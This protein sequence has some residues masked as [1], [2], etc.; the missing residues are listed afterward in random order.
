MTNLFQNEI[1]LLRALFIIVLSV[2]TVVT[3]KMIYIIFAIH[4]LLIYTNYVEGLFVGCSWRWMIWCDFIQ[5]LLINRVIF[6]I[7]VVTGE[8]EKITNVCSRVSQEN[9]LEQGATTAGDN[10][11]KRSL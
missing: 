6:N 1:F 10:A 8:T 3:W 9:E 7:L 11:G 2:K 5:S 4:S